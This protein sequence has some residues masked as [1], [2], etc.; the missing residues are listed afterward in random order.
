[1]SLVCRAR[2]GCSSDWSICS[3]PDTTGSSAVETCSSSRSSARSRLNRTSDASF[4]LLLLIFDRVSVCVC[5]SSCFQLNDDDFLLIILVFLVD[6]FYRLL[7]NCCTLGFAIVSHVFHSN[8]VCVLQLACKNK[9]KTSLT[10]HF[11]RII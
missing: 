6:S 10:C 9:I 8:R 7:R 11:F 1:M 4:L 2:C 5:V 3:W